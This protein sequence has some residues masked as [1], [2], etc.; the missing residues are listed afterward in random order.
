MQAV[1]AASTYRAGRL[2]T[3]P[4][5]DLEGVV[6]ALT[7]RPCGKVVKRRSING[8]VIVGDGTRKRSSKLKRER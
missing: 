5:A 7:A 6:Q 1:A 8:V 2:V 4:A 3:N